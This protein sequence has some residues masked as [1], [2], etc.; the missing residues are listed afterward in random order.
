MVEVLAALAGS[1]LTIGSLGVGSA[2]ARTRKANDSVTRLTIA[3]E[4]I[5]K[6]LDE[7]HLD[8][9]ADRQATFSSLTDLDRRVTKLEARQ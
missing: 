9:K 3:V 8:I 4:N 7:I 5:V 6:R 2:F 1:A